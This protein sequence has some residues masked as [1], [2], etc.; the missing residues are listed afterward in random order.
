MLVF[1]CCLVQASALKSIEKYLGTL[2]GYT[3]GAERKGSSSRK[4]ASSCSSDNSLIFLL[5][6]SL[7]MSHSW[8][9]NSCGFLP[10]RNC[11]FHMPLLFGDPGLIVP[12]EHT[13]K[14]ALKI[15]HKP[16]THLLSNV[17]VSNL[18]AK[19]C[20]WGCHSQVHYYLDQLSLRQKWDRRE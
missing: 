7:Q 15:K 2:L 12:L 5:R 9:M 11:F 6:P 20:N 18:L 17:K 4:P 14:R 16:K 10:C 1:F 8:L 13:E 19:V 3:A